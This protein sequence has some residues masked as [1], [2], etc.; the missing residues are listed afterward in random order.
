MYKCDTLKMDKLNNT[1][2]VQI[3]VAAVISSQREINTSHFASDMP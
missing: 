2:A 3:C 1:V